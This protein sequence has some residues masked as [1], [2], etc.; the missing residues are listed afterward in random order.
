M[1]WGISRLSGLL[2]K[3]V[4]VSRFLAEGYADT[5]IT[6]QKRLAVEVLQ[7]MSNSSLAEW[8]AVEG[9]QGCRATKIASAVGFRPRGL[10]VRAKAARQLIGTCAKSTVLGSAASFSTESDSPELLMLTGSDWSAFPKDREKAMTVYKVENVRLQTNEHVHMT[11]Q[12]IIC[13][14]AVCP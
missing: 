13:I 14:E 6:R 11:E 12:C 2:S 9:L 5:S 1:S 3:L 7:E 8:R 4:L 10:A